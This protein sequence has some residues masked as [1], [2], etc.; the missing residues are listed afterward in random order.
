MAEESKVELSTFY[1]IKA[2]M[3]RVFSESGDH[4]P[5][6]VIKLIPNVISQVKTKEKDGYEAYQVAFCE[7]REKLVNKSVKGHLAKAS[8]KQSFSKCAEIRVDGVSAENLGKEIS[9]ESFKPSTYIDVT[10]VSI[11]KGFQ[12]VMKRFNFQGGPAAHG[13]HFHRRPGSIGNRATPARVFAEKKMPGHMGCVTKT[14]QNNIVYE[15]NMANGYLLIKGSVPGPK[16]G[17]VKIS[18]AIKKQG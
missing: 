4:V 8:I 9:I 17:V 2:G 6:T 5:V 12:G 7:K 3:T 15:V 11:G 10:G 16:N 1:G 14:Q 13:S 18:K